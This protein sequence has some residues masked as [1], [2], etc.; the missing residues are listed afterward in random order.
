MAY[1]CIL[2]YPQ[3]SRHGIKSH[4]IYSIYKFRYLFQVP[5]FLLRRI[6]FQPIFHYESWCNRWPANKN[7]Y[8]PYQELRNSLFV[9]WRKIVPIDV[10]EGH[11]RK[12]RPLFKKHS[13]CKEWGEEKERICAL[14][15][16][17]NR[18]DHSSASPCSSQMPPCM[19]N[20]SGGGMMR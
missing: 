15:I 5:S 4:P 1:I 10:G 9:L 6:T 3:Y 11:H 8:S 20:E 12:A 13:W 17:S 7:S 14:D 16:L 18:A 19:R 2:Q